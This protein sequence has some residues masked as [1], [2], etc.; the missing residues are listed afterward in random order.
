ME[1]KG[2][3]GGRGRVTQLPRREPR[4]S[5]QGATGSERREAT[6]GLREA[7]RV[8]SGLHE[9]A[10]TGPRGG[11]KGIV[12]RPRTTGARG[13]GLRRATGQGRRPWW[14]TR[15][16]TELSPS[17]PHQKKELLCFAP[18]W[19]ES[20]QRPCRRYLGRGS[21]QVPAE[22]ARSGTAR[23]GAENRGRKTFGKGAHHEIL[24]REKPAQQN[25][26]TRRIS[27]T[28]QATASNKRTMSRI[29]KPP[30]RQNIASHMRRHPRKPQ[31]ETRD[32]P[33]GPRKAAWIYVKKP[34]WHAF[35]M[36]GNISTRPQQLP[37][38]APGCN[39]KASES[40]RVGAPLTSKD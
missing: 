12:R 8:P 39:L 17:R 21:E 18:R 22:R 11:Q 3:G 28:Q 33:E 20:E 24:P 16:K 13:R 36:P 1:R 6:G 34:A 35:R 2:R 4:G 38:S 15:A 9:E 19:A 37:E 7:T 31:E 32:A 27:S 25:G 29:N 10:T 23:E 40:P 14:I 5:C 30:P 26:I